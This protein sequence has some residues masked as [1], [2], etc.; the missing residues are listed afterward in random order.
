LFSSSEAIKP[1]TKTNDMKSILF[2][3]AIT[4]ANAAPSAAF[5]TALHKVETSGRHGAILGDN[6][7]ALGPLQIHR[8]YWRDS[9]VAGRYEQCADLAYSRRVVAAYL[10]KF[11]PAAWAKGDALTLARVHNGGPSGHHK[12]ATIAYANRVRRAMK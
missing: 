12:T 8:A 11:A 9:G 4:V 6:G 2:L 1:E 5:F 10:Q 3:A 7:A